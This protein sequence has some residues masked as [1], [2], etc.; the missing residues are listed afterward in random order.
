MCEYTIF[1]LNNGGHF[2][3]IELVTFGE[4]T[5]FRYFF[6]II[7]WKIEE[8]KDIREYIYLVTHTCSTDNRKLVNNN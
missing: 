3:I 1:S 6:I 4:L 7:V 8:E 5:Y 2:N